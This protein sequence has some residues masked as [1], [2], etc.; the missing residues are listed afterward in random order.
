MATTRPAQLAHR[1]L[2]AVLLAVASVVALPP[3]AGAAVPGETLGVYAGAGDPSAVARFEAQIGRPVA[4]VHDALA[5]ENW[6]NLSNPTWFAGQWTASP[7][8]QRVVYTVPMLPDSGGTLAEGARGAYNMYFRTLALRLVAG[9]E[10]SAILR[11]GPEFNGNWFRWSITAPNGAAD[12]AAF[13]RQIVD[14]MRA[15]PGANFKFDWCPN[16]GSSWVAGQQLQAESAYPGDAYV[17]YV[18]LDVYDQSWGPNRADPAARWKELVTT[19]NG[20]AWQRD[21]ARAHGK[22]MTFP[23]WGLANRT[24]GYGGGDSP[25]FIEQ[26]YEW[27]R[28]ND[29]AYH[30]YFEYGDSVAD[31]ALFNG[32]APNAS[33]RFVELFGGGSTGAPLPE[34]RAAAGGGSAASPAPAAVSEAGGG[35]AQHDPAGAAGAVGPGP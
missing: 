1:F 28:T 24:D 19:R 35:A 27:I 23:E 20:L 9:G 17:D 13:W 5:R 10:G 31:Y 11:I 34:P 22:P 26:M 21:F 8:R 6:A 18:G 29:V 33:R 14:T 12:F 2:I 30:M 25:H 16:G 7:Y 15:V 32:W 4:V 3:M